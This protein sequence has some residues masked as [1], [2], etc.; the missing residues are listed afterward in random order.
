MK[1]KL[2]FLLAFLCAC[3]T[4]PKV[5]TPAAGAIDSHTFTMAKSNDLNI[6]SECERSTPDG[7]RFTVLISNSGNK[8]HNVQTTA[9]SAVTKEGNKLK[10][11]GSIS[12]C[13]YFAD[14][15]KN[16]QLHSSQECKPEMHL[17]PGDKIKI[18]HWIPLRSDAFILPDVFSELY[19]H[20]KSFI[21]INFANVNG[22]PWSAQCD[23]L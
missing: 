13:Y 21:K 15:N 7:V 22:K 11:V 1:L 16:L 2:S 9:F 8:T 19:I 6:W 20:P 10:K 5:T 18:S 14:S 17:A 3:T 4:T 23:T 12:Y